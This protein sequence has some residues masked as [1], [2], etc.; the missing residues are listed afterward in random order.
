MTPFLLLPPCRRLS[1]HLFRSFSLA[2]ASRWIGSSSGNASAKKLK[3]AVADSPRFEDFQSTI[4][5]LDAPC[6]LRSCISHWPALSKWTDLSNLKGSEAGSKAI[7]I[8][9]SCIRAGE[10]VAEGYNMKGQPGTSWDRVEMPL[11]VFL[12]AMMIGEESDVNTERWAAYLAQYPLL[13][14]V[15]SPVPFDRH[16][17]AESTMMVT[18]AFAPK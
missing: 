14:E 18:G 15:C 3:L 7:P 2:R 9:V 1:N 4:L 6:L 8:E 12:D 5:A 17:W 11:D 16:S 13:D 10:T